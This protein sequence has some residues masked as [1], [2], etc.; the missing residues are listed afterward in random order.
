MLF[1]LVVRNKLLLLLLLLTL[2][3]TRTSDS[4]AKGGL[5]FINIVFVS[6]C[7]DLQYI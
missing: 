5:D 6:V 1:Y 4:K 7:G 3:S 2:L